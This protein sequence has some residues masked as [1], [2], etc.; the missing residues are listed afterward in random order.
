MATCPVWNDGVL[1]DLNGNPLSNGFIYCY[2][3]GS[4]TIQLQPPVQ[5]NSDGSTGG[6][7]TIP[8]SVYCNLKLTDQY[9][10][11]IQV[12]DPV[13]GVPP[14]WNL[15][16]SSGGGGGNSGGS[17]FQSIV[18]DDAGIYALA[19]GNGNSIYTANGGTSW[20][21]ETTY[22]GGYYSNVQFNGTYFVALSFSGTLYFSS[23]LVSW[24]TGPTISG[25]YN[26]YLDAGTGAIY[27]HP[28]GSGSG[29]TVYRNAP[30]TDTVTEILANQPGP[31]FGAYPPILTANNITVSTYGSYPTYTAY[32][33]SDGGV[34]WTAS[35]T[36]FGSGNILYGL[37]YNGSIWLLITANTGLT[38]TPT[39]SWTSVDGKTWTQVLSTLSN[40]PYQTQLWTF[41]GLF[42][43]AYGAA[44]CYSSDGINW[45]Q[46]FSL[47]Y[48]YGLATS[49]TRAYLWG[50]YGISESTDGINY[51]ATNV[52]TSVNDLVASGL[53]LAITTNG[54]N[55][56][57]FKRTT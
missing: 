50:P 20:Q 16:G 44:Y 39:Q 43:Q 27:L 15:S 56:Q 36:N 33:S 8:S 26:L 28:F 55:A 2:Q 34:T 11:V 9:G 46:T 19:A 32:W 12:I 14:P 30:N 3:G 18:S 48:A 10:N 47:P 6:T 35:S 22:P 38:G 54:T 42:I 51:T 40:P 24:V 49:S 29:V 45:T 1:Y 57:V 23:N 52:T 13:V 21:A 7:F 17:T 53:V 31:N 37:G 41:N 25:A 5:L 4:W